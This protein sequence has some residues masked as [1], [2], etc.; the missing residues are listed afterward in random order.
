MKTPEIVT[1]INMFIFYDMS[2]NLSMQTF[3]I[4]VNYISI[5]IIFQYYSLFLLKKSKAYRFYT[6]F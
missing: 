3:I 6:T 5:S 2:S 1:Y 4:L